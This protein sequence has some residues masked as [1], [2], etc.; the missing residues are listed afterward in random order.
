MASVTERVEEECR[1]L[2]SFA[3]RRI[4]INLAILNPTFDY[5]TVTAPV[6]PHR[7]EANLHSVWQAAKEYA[8]EFS[9]VEVEVDE[10]VG[11]EVEEVS[12]GGE[13]GSGDAAA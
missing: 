3:T 7:R 9:T 5:A 11:E 12:S 1:D 13:G 4:F 8:E 6:D 10:G 2:L